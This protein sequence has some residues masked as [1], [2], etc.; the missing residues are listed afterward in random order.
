MSGSK[1]KG[2]IIPSSDRLGYYPPTEEAEK[3]FSNITDLSSDDNTEELAIE[4]RIKVLE[5]Q[6]EKSKGIISF[7][8]RRVL[9]KET[10]AWES[11]VFHAYTFDKALIGRIEINYINTDRPSFDIKV[12]PDTRRKGYAYE[13]LSSAISAAFSYFSFDHMEYDVLKD[14]TASI[15]LIQKIGGQLVYEDE[16]GESYII[17]RD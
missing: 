6:I 9:P 12:L 14:N 5:A 2:F 15:K 16:I 8:K 3:I 17:L 4:D 13:M 10:D 1:Y 7:L 11:C